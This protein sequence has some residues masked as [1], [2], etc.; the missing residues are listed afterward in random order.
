MA[1]QHKPNNGSLFVNQDKVADTQPSWTGSA[2]IDGREYRLAAWENE[3]RNGLY[4]S[5]KFTDKE[6]WDNRQNRR[7][8]PE[9]NRPRGRT[10]GHGRGG[11]QDLDYGRYPDPG[12]ARAAVE[13]ARRALSGQGADPGTGLTP[14]ESDFADEDIPF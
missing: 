6:E 11:R 3:S 4:L 8:D 12:R 7:A 10:G 14:G 2:L 5:I 1:F 13:K 9:S